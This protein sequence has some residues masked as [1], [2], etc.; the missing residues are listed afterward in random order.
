MLLSLTIIL[1]GLYWL[2]LETN[3][4][5]VNLAYDKPV[6]DQCI[7]QHKHS[8]QIE[9]CRIVPCTYPIPVPIKLLAEFCGFTITQN[10]IVKEKWKSINADEFMNRPRCWTSYQS[11]NIG[12]HSIS[13]LA[14]SSK[15]YDTIAE[16]QKIADSK[17]RKPAL[18]LAPINWF[19][20]LCGKEW[21]NEHMNDHKD[22][23]PTIELTVNEKSISFNGNYKTGCIKTWVKAN[24]MAWE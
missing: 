18:K 24:K 12:G 13:L 3:W 1:A 16:F 9:P 2:M 6:P 21:Y 15:L 23:E 8:P 20:P 22:F 7:E 14:T 10:K 11:M 19:N 5:T 4:L 17:D